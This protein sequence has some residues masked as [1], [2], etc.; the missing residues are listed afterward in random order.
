MFFDYEVLLQN[1]NEIQTEQEKENEK[2]NI[3]LENEG[4]LKSS[5]IS[6]KEKAENLPIF[7]SEDLEID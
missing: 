7:E 5:E 6:E 1:I 4:E 2:Q 3:N